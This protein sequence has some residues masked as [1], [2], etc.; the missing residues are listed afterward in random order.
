[1]PEWKEEIRKRLADLRLAPLRE[2][3]I[4]EELAQHCD[5]LY[6]ELLADG[7]S[8]AEAKRGILDDLHDQDC[9]P[10]ELRQ[11]ERQ[12]AEEVVIAGSGGRKMIADLWQD[13]RL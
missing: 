5:Q 13:T 2:A 10:R 3:E 1:M 11:V 8:P 12:V 7:A 6:E 9:L 4:V